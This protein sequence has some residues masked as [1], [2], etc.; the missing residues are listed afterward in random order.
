MKQAFNQRYL[1]SYILKSPSLSMVF[2]FC[3]CVLRHF[4]SICDFF[5]V[6]LGAMTNGDAKNKHI[7]LAYSIAY[8]SCVFN[9]A[10]GAQI[11]LFGF[12][13]AHQ[14]RWVSKSN[15]YPPFGFSD[16]FLCHLTIRRKWLRL[17][18]SGSSA[19]KQ[20]SPSTILQKC[21]CKRAERP[22]FVFLSAGAIMRRMIRS[23]FHSVESE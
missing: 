3:L 10:K 19:R 20:K 21:K 12:F 1:I 2:H 18:K 4:C 17:K 8:N 16:K 14:N 5:A 7:T 9:R 23:D 13:G 6:R 15:C 22:I 11:V